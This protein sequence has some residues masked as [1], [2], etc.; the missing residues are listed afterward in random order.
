MKWL[1]HAI[2]YKLIQIIFSNLKS[3]PTQQEQ[4]LSR[5]LRFKKKLKGI[6]LHKRKIQELLKP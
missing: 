1:W 3:Y 6:W 2:L 4:S 5:F